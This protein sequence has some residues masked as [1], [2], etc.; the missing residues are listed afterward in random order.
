MSCT[1]DLVISGSGT[2][3]RAAAGDALQHGLRV[4]VVLAGTRS[5]GRR[6]RRNLGEAGGRVGRQLTVVTDAE[7]VCVDGANGVEAVVIRS[8]RTGLLH[9][10]NA[11]A[12]LA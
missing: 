10:V 3:A 2:A 9:A 7:V 4:L 5:E 1:V 11:T 6:L 8:R 12:Y